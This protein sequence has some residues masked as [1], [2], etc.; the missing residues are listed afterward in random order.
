M[1]IRG[2]V[3]F[4][5][6]CN[7]AET[8]QTLRWARYCFLSYVVCTRRWAWT[9][10][11]TF[12]APLSKVSSC[13]SAEGFAPILTSPSLI[14]ISWESISYTMSS[15]SFLVIGYVRMCWSVR[16]AKSTIIK[17]SA[18][19]LGMHQ[20]RSRLCWQC[21]CTTAFWTR[22]S[23]IGHLWDLLDSLLVESKCWLGD[24]KNRSIRAKIGRNPHN[25]T[26]AFVT[27]LQ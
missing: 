8:P 22:M 7:R 10:L 4:S 25:Q 14:M 13:S 24:E 26:N 5:R 27:E 15:M 20:K 11:L 21:L 16:I 9:T 18:H 23:Q 1:E 3:W 12:C 2:G 17:R 6:L 19:T